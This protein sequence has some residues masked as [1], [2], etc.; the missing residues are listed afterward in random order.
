MVLCVE[1]V[2]LVVHCHRG[3]AVVAVV[4]V[5]VIQKKSRAVSEC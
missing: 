4:R 1:L 2:L 3:V 5:V